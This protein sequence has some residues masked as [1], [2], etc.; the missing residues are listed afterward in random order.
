MIKQ[1]REE[2]ICQGVHVMAIGREQLV[3][4]I[5]AAAGM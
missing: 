2:K 1:L 3:P 4:E 5:L